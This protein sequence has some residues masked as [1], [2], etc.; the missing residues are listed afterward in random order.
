MKTRSTSIIA[1]FVVIFLVGGGFIIARVITEGS[2]SETKI[3]HADKALSSFEKAETLVPAIIA[4]LSDS[5][6]KSTDTRQTAEALVGHLSEALSEI[7]AADKINFE[8]SEH[9][10]VAGWEAMFDGVS[11]DHLG[12]VR[13]QNAV[14][15]GDISQAKYVGQ[16]L[17]EEINR[18][19]DILH[20]YVLALRL[21]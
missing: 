12:G 1:L 18:V 3:E 15:A 11:S 21:I 2:F 19:K 13:F 10:L 5:D 17:L 9:P 8:E 14:E 4:D 6:N 7:T 16:S 20:Q